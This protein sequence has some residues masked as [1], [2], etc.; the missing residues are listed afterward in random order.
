LVETRIHLC[1]R[2]VARVDGVRV[3]NAL[4]GRQGRLL[5][6]YLAL[7]RARSATRDELTEVLWPAEQ[8]AAAES[9][10]SALLSKLRRVV[11]IG[12]GELRLAL[13]DGAWIDV[14]AAR[15]GLHRAQAAV[16]RGDWP[17]AWSAGRVVQHIAARELL[18]GERAEWVETRRRELEELYLRSLELV[19]RT[20]VEI[21]GGELDTAERCGRRLIARAPY[22][23]SGYRLLMELLEG[24]GDAA[25]ALLVYDELRRRLRDELGVAPSALT[26]TV[27][28]RILA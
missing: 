3:E 11:P 20:C 27:Y 19:G 5:F 4:P 13:A 17:T 15:E 25:E 6:A 12:S 2:L 7:T 9:A 23:E 24:R 1:G 16:A 8:P 10:L 21:G 26:Q 18:P 22:R 14:E 28:K